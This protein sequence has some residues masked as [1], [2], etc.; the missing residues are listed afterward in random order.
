[1]NNLITGSEFHGQRNNSCNGVGKVLVG[2]D[3]NKSIGPNEGV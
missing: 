2:H 3:P 1:M